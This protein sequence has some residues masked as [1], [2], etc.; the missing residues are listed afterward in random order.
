M[1][2]VFISY[3]FKDS[4]FAHQ[5]A[6]E[7]SKCGIDIWIE[8]DLKDSGSIS[9][10]AQEKL[11]FAPI[12]VVVISPSSQKSTRV[13]SELSEAL[14]RKKAIYPV[15]LAG[16]KW[17]DVLPSIKYADLLHPHPVRPYT[18]ARDGKIPKRIFFANLQNL[19]GLKTSIILDKNQDFPPLPK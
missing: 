18:D 15:L 5:L 2:Q 10:V 12:M 17:D 4:V 11:D 3:S 8:D 9:P 14:K 7:V 19:L 6:D 13:Q 16:E 1:A